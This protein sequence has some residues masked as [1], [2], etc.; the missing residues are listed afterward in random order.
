MTRLKRWQLR[1]AVI[2]A[3]VGSVLVAPVVAQQVVRIYG[4]TSGGT[5]LPALVDSTG[6]LLVDL[7]GGTI[8]PTSV[9]L[10][11]TT[12]AAPGVYYAS[13]ATTGIAF[14][15]TPSVI[16]CVNGVGV[17]TT[18]STAVTSTVPVVG[19]VGSAAATSFNFGT[20][21]TGFYQN[22]ANDVRIGIAGTARYA[23]QAADFY[24]LNDAAAIYLGSGADVS[25]SRLAADVVAV[26]VGD[27]YGLASKAFIN[28][29]PTVTSAG[30]SPSVTAS[31]GTA[32]FRVNTG[33][34]GVATDIVMA[35]PAATT[36]WNCYAENITATAANRAN[37]RVVFVSSTT[38]SITVRNTTISTGAA[39]AFTASDI[40][41]FQCTAF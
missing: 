11:A 5:F 12:C 31:N 24:V 2:A 26:G 29:A 38:T 20:A 8:T 1:I 10:P 18:T 40:V 36:G 34:G 28:T 23:F 22:A 37:Q 7:T 41:A 16:L 21:G 35:M 30:T 3:F 6:R 17:L 25:L 15:A 19:P 4:T 27:A 9:G 32:A 13:G 33:T 39:L 14:T